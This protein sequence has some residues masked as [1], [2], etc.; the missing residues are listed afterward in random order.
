[1]SKLKEQIEALKAGLEERSPHWP[2]KKQ[3]VNGPGPNKEFGQRVVKRKDDWECECGD[4][5]CACEGPSGEQKTVKIKRG[6]KKKYNKRYKAWKAGKGEHP[7]K[8]KKIKK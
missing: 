4:Y 1:M 2:F 6:Y 3:A 7:S 5:E 8:L